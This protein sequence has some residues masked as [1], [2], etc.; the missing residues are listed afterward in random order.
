[1]D[2]TITFIEN[3]DSI[4]IT[5]T[6][7]TSLGDEEGHNI[8]RMTVNLTALNGQL[9]K[10]EFIFFRTPGGVDFLNHLNMPL[11][12]RYISISVNSSASIYEQA[13]TS[14]FYLNDEEEPTIYNSSNGTDRLMRAII[15]SITDTNYIDPTTD[16][17]VA[18]DA[19]MGIST[20]TIRIG[21]EI[22]PVNDNR[23][24]ILIRSD[25]D[26]CST[27]SDNFKESDTMS[28]RRRGVR[29]VS[30]ITKKSVSL[31]SKREQSYS[32]VRD[33]QLAIINDYF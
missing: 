20:T 25:P 23:P 2:H 17:A 24:R 13:L 11:T 15:I 14:I 21:I 32:M 10:N 33:H 7:L 29:S 12:D 3:G 22:T 28:R 31:R 30:R 1:M 19:D 27:D 4:P 16:P 18:A 9:D 6:F 26:S 8:S 5:Q